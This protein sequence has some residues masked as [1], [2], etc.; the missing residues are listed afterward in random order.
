[1]QRILSNSYWKWM[2][3]STR[4][5]L[6]LLFFTGGLSKLIPF[7]NLMGPVWLEQELAKYGLELFARFIAYMQLITG[8]LLLTR[9]FQLLG[10]IMLLPMLLNI[11][12]ITISLQWRGTPYVVGF[13]LI[14]NMLLLI[15]DYPRLLTLINDDTA[16]IHQLNFKRRNRKADLLL[17]LGSM[18]LLAGV[19]CYDSSYGT[20]WTMIA[21][22]SCVLLMAACYELIFRK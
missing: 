16:S 15:D 4:I 11:L 22:G 7:P 14:Q 6:G 12:I 10:A 17:M 19:T 8:I 1:M 20:A 9:R 21:F 3:V 18:I 2:I 5:F 13:F